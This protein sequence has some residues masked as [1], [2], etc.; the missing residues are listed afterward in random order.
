MGARA[1]GLRRCSGR[2]NCELLPH[3]RVPS[4]AAANKPGSGAETEAEWGLWATRVL[5]IPLAPD[6]ARGCHM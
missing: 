1:Q 4:T 3:Q 5:E 6:A 2:L